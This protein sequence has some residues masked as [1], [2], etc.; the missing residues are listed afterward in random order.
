MLGEAERRR[1]ADLLAMVA[2]R[3][4]RDAY[5]QLF[6]YYAPR[7]KSYLMR[8]GADSALAEEIA[9]DVMVTVWRKAALFDR[10]QA[11]VS[12]WIF[13]VARNRRIDVFRRAKRPD[14]DPEE[15]MLLPAGVEAPDARLEAMEADARVRAAMV[16]LPEEQVSLLRLA[17]YEGLSHSEIAGKLDLPLGTVKSRIRLAF[18]KMKARLEDD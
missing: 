15:T 6:S 18:A 8:L 2:E 7:V 3:Q 1:F 4:D 12:T 16:D 10:T 13:R 14:L 5:A 11:S 9:Q 17:F